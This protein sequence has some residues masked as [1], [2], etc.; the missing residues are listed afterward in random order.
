[1][2]DSKECVEPKKDDSLGFRL[3][4]WWY[5][6]NP[7]PYSLRFWWGDQD[8]LHPRRTYCKT[9]RLLSWVPVLWDD[10]DFD[11]SGIY[12]ILYFKLK[13]MHEEQSTNSHHVDS[14]RTCAEMAVARDCAHRLWKD[15]YLSAEWEAHY[16]RWPS[17]FD[18]RSEWIHLPNGS[19]Q[20]PNM[21]EQ[22][23]ENFTRLADEEERLRRADMDQLSKSLATQI[24]GW[25]D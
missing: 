17:M 2:D 10:V 21:K 11:Y 16:T 14:G 3:R 4:V 12:H 1:M 23:S 19:V 15:S 20:M 8:W 24:R 13:S 18:R 6:N 5:E 7:F 22:E 25:W 9:V